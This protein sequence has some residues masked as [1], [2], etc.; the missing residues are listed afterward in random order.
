MEARSPA[1]PAAN[2]GLCMSLS[3]QHPTPCQI[4][5]RPMD[6]LPVT[7]PQT[8]ARSWQETPPNGCLDPANWAATTLNTPVAS[9]CHPETGLLVH[10]CRVRY[11][12][13]LMTL[14]PYEFLSART[15]GSPPTKS[16]SSWGY[17][18]LNMI[19]RVQVHSL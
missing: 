10:C 8:N 6:P 14:C 18:G 1:S 16:I 11:N 15:A 13:R 19:K 7:S 3:S 5:Q 2:L 4:E 9:N 12:E 17:Q